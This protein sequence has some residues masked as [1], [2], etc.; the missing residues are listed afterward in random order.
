MAVEHEIAPQSGVAVLG[1]PKTEQTV[2]V[3]GENVIEFPKLKEFQQ[4]TIRAT[5]IL[6]DERTGQLVIRAGELS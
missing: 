5:R 3:E 4:L 2:R 1:A 6:T